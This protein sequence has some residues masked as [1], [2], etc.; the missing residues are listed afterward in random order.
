[1]TISPGSSLGA[2]LTAVSRS[3]PKSG[4]LSRAPTAPPSPQGRSAVDLSADSSFAQESGLQRAA[5]LSG[6]L[7]K[8]SQDTRDYENGTPK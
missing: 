8:I 5:S 7:R 4:G 2:A 1:M 3:S 6:I